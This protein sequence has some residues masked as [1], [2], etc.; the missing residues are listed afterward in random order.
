MLTSYAEFKYEQTVN[1]SK[2]RQNYEK[3]QNLVLTKKRQYDIIPRLD[4]LKAEVAEKRYF[5]LPTGNFAGVCPYQS[6]E[7]EF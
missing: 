2:N 3:N 5:R 6:G 4:A 1:L 7:T